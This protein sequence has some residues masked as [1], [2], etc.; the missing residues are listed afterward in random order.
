MTGSANPP[1]E[2]FA[3]SLASSPNLNET[4]SGTL[5][6]ADSSNFKVS[7]TIAVGQEITQ[8]V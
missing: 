2:P 8:C 6:L 3:F 7:T 5:H 1:P 4:K